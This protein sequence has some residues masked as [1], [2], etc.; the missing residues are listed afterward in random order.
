MKICFVTTYIGPRHLADISD[1]FERVD[2]CDYLLFT[3]LTDVKITNG[4]DVII[5]DLEEFAYLNSAIKISRYFKFMLHEYFKKIGRDYDFVFYCD[6]YK[7]P[8]HTI[9]WKKGCNVLETHDTGIMQYR[10]TCLGDTMSVSREIDCIVTAQKE[11]GENMQKTRKYL[12]S[13]DN[14]VDIN[15]N[16]YF[17]NSIIGFHLKNEYAISQCNE[18]WKYYVN[19]PTYRD[20]PLWNFLYLKNNKIPYVENKLAELY[21]SKNRRNR[22]MQ[23]YK[24]ANVV[25]AKK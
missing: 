5:I 9:N 7:Y 20:Q 15:K 13:I 2:G 25:I 21:V 22:H 17:E 10:H 8:K 6:S 18:F 24:D 14:S 12:K 19:S 1:N 4:W 16:Q 11:T 23:Q 3:N